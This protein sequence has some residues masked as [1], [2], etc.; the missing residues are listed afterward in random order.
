MI[1]GALL[2][3]ALTLLPIAAAG[4]TAAPANQGPMTVERVHNGFLVVPDFKVTDF[5]RHASELAG[6]Y[7][8][9]L[10]DDRFFIGG[11]GYWTPDESR[12][13]RLE[14]GGAIVQWFMH[15]DRRVGLSAKALVGGGRATVGTTLQQA[16]DLDRLGPDLRGMGFNDPDM[17]RLIQGA[18]PSTRVRVRQD[19]FLAE[20]EVDAV[21]RITSRLRL[22]AGIGYRLTTTDRRDVTRL[23]G[24]TGSLGLQIGFGL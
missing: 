24:A 14:Y 11:G 5:D 8:G 22:A 12:D 1:R 19:F 10:Y 7:A 13:R 9:W 15:T 3:S 21:V 20:P 17:S 23:H 2:A 4:Q 18:L 16:F 6:A